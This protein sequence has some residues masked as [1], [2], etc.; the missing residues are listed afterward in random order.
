MLPN[1]II[2]KIIPKIL[3]QTSSCY[4]LRHTLTTKPRK[5]WIISES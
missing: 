1:D 5:N 4:L 3:G 2:G